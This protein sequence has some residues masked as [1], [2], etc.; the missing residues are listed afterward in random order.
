MSKLFYNIGKIWGVE[1]EAQFQEAGV[2][3]AV[4]E[5]LENA[6]ILTEH[7]LVLGFGN[8][9][10]PEAEQMVDLNGGELLPGFVDSRHTSSI[11]PPLLSSLFSYSSVLQNIRID[12]RSIIY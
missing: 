4:V 10:P 11:R 5:H 9:E 7:G 2:E 3:M 6:W 12:W 8:T 1:N